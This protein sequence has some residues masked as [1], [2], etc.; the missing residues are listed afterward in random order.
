MKKYILLI[1]IVIFAAAA[2][3]Q[4]TVAL[5]LKVKGD[6][7][8]NRSDSEA[9]LELGDTLINKDEL[10]SKEDSFAAVRFVDGNA[11]IKLFSNSRLIISA[12]KK[13]DKYDKKSYL[14][15]GTLWSKVTK[16]SGSFDVETPT[17]VVSVRGTEFVIEVDKDGVTKVYAISGKVT[18]KNK[19]TGQVVDL[20]AGEYTEDDDENPMEPG[21][22]DWTEVP[23]EIADEVGTPQVIELELENNDGEKRSVEIK[24][25]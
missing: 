1:L 11:F 9:K 18:V 12:D 7:N 20:G 22:T 17:T 6:V 3:A 24:F 16:N 25:E 15:M 21:E 5:T 10:I 23:E 4:D 19:K 2:F 13:E 8:L 14:K